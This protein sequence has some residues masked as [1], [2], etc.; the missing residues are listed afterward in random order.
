[1]TDVLVRP[2]VLDD[3]PRLTEIY[4]YYIVNS[5]ITFDIETY[6]VERRTA[7]FE[8]FALTGRYRLLVAESN[9][10]VVGYTGTTRFRPKAAY[11]TTVETTI[12]CAPE[13]TR[14]GVGGLLYAALFEA[15][16]IEDINRVLAGYTL[17]NPASAALHQRFGFKLA[18]VFNENGRKFGRYWDVAWLERPL[19]LGK[20]KEL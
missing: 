1:M 18:G 12:Y 11:D 7:W 20:A 2:A 13:T 4:N 16:S 15:I 17:P 9:G 6:T 19:K 8:Q 5:P 14:K 3:L 10:T